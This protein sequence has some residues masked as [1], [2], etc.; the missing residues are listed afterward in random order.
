MGSSTSISFP[1]PSR[2]LHLPYCS[3]LDAARLILAQ[4]GI[5][6]NAADHEGNTPLHLA[7]FYNEYEIAMLLCTHGA[8]V[9]ARNALAQ[10]PIIMSEDETML[11]LLSMLDKRQGTLGPGDKTRPTSSGH[12]LTRDQQHARSHSFHSCCC[13]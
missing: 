3:Y 8:N 1:P 13:L 6:V 5:A 9:H 2:S 7:S 4:P 11:R 12:R 10:R